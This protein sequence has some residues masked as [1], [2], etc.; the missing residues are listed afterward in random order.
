MLFRSSMFLKQ[1]FEPVAI[2]GLLPDTTIPESYLL[3]TI[4]ELK[5]SEQILTTPMQVESIDVNHRLQTEF[6]GSVAVM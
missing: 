6:E 3:L 2:A 5:L 1:A 4:V